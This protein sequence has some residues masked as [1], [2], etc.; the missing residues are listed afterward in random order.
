[1]FS[2]RLSVDDFLAGY[3]RFGVNL[4]LTRIQRLLARLGHP[5]QQ[6]PI[7]HVAGTNG[8]G[9]VC[10]YLSSVLA[11]AGYR[12]GRYTSPHL[13]G[14][15]ERICINQ[16]PITNEALRHHL[17]RVAGA[18]D[19]E[20]VELPTQFEVFTAAA[21]SY[22]ADQAVDLAVVEVGLG[23]RLDATNVCPEPLVSV[24]VS[25]SRDHWQCLGPTLADIAREKAGI[26]KMGRPVVIGP[27]PES[28]DRVVRQRATALNCPLHDVMPALETSSNQS[29]SSL[30]SSGLDGDLITYESGLLGEHQRVNSGIAIATLQLLQR[31]GW[32]ISTEAIQQGMAAT[33]WPGRLQWFTWHDGQRWLI[34]GAHN[35]AAAQM[36]RKYIDH[37]PQPVT[38]LIGMLATKDHAD[39]LKALLRPGD[40][41]YLVPVSGPETA[42]P[43]DLA[44]LAQSV[45]IG[46]MDC[47]TYEEFELA[48]TA[49][50]AASSSTKVLCGSLYLI[51]DFLARFNQS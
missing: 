24:I 11:V 14:W 19:A 12:V 29:L 33:Q 23:G 43:A 47:H 2:D 50:R 41:L 42:K 15:N 37:L 31:Q 13:L 17:F 3:G 22:F 45:C 28:A 34:D 30:W 39:I 21:W 44:D 35:P 46:P 9:S 1:M 51:G 26:I 6:V 5:Q 4:G 10:A 27:L 16:E 32:S 20:D 40:T 48:L 18:I 7:V 49:V 25:L 38:W 8:K 36:L